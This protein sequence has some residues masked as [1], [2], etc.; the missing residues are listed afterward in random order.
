MTVR[1]YFAPKATGADRASGD[2]RMQAVIEVRMLVVELGGPAMFARISVTRG[3]DC[4]RNLTVTRKSSNGHDTRALQAY[5]GHRNIQHRVR[6]T[7]LS[8]DRFKNFW[9]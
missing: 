8:P 7:E 2:L 5:L 4:Y 6:Y 1:S 3:I 9:R